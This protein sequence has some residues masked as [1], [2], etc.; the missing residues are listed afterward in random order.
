MNMQSNVSVEDKLAVLQAHF[1]AIMEEL[2]N[3]AKGNDLTAD[4]IIEFF[5]LG[6]AAV[7]DNDTNFKSPR[8]MRRAAEACAKLIDRRARDFRTLNEAAG[9]SSLEILLSPYPI[10]RAVAT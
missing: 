6:I 7:I 8:E 9:F 3:L 4:D 10:S 5:A 2:T 1:P